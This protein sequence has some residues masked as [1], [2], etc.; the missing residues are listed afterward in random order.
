MYEIIENSMIMLELILF[1][2]SFFLLAIMASSTFEVT[3]TENDAEKS[4]SFG[5][6]ACEENGIGLSAQ[7]DGEVPKDHTYTKDP[8]GSDVRLLRLEL[9]KIKHCKPF[10]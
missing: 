6:E 10:V 9:L 2:F 8:D 4:L 7:V 1:F 5:L 3:D